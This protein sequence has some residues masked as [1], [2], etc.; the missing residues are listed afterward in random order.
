MKRS[1]CLRTSFG[2]CLSPYYFI[3]PEFDGNTNSVLYESIP[4]Q[5]VVEWHKNDGKARFKAVRTDTGEE[6]VGAPLP[7]MLYLIP[8]VQY[9]HHSPHL[10]HED[11]H[12]ASSASCIDLLSCSTANAASSNRW[13]YTIGTTSV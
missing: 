6:L 13:K 5:V 1:S 11:Q 4:H 12:R 2:H 10:I 7:T 3:G 8:S 9:L